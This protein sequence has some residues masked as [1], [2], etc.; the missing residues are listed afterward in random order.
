MCVCV[1]VCV[2]KGDLTHVSG[3]QTIHPT[4]PLE[5]GIH[6]CEGCL[7]ISALFKITGIH[8]FHMQVN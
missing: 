7:A 5:C 3:S 4:P 8:M 6:E 1:C 2:S